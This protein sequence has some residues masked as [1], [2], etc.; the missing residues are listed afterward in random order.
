MLVIGLGN[1]SP[2]Y[3]GTRH[4]IGTAAVTEWFLQFETAKLITVPGVTT[5]LYRFFLADQDVIACPQLGCFMNESGLAVEK[6]LNFFKIDAANIIVV[7]DE[8]AFSLGTVRIAFAASAAGHNGVQSIIE[9]LG[10]SE[11]TRVRLGIETRVSK[12]QPPNDNFVLQKFSTDEQPR[13]KDVINKAGSALDLILTRD[14]E[15]A[16]TIFNQ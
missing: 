8:L 12:Q 14:R 11:F 4:N 15:S 2:Q 7:H 6:I 3:D 16:M 5:P 1:P 10:T 9:A 13:A